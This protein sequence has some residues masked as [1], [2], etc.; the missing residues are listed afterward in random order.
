MTTGAC[1]FEDGSCVEVDTAADCAALGG[2]FQG[3]GT[4]CSGGCPSFAGA[5]C[6]ADGSCVLVDGPSDCEAQGGDFLGVGTDCSVGCPVLEGACCFE[7]GTCVITD[8][9]SEC[10]SLGGVFQGKGTDCSSGCPSFAGACCFGDGTCVIA[11]GPSDCAAQ[12]GNFLGVGTNCTECPSVVGAC[13]FSDGSCQQTDA[14]TCAA[15]GGQFHGVGSSCNFCNVQGLAAATWTISASPQDPFANVVSQPTFGVVERYLW[16]A[17][18]QFPFQPE[19]IAAAELGISS[20]GT[21]H[22]AT[23]PQNGFLN[24]GTTADL[25]LAVGGCPC[26]PVVAATLLVLDQPGAMCF[27]PSSVSGVKAAVDC[28]AN[29]EAWAMHWTGF[30][31]TGGQPCEK[32]FGCTL[33]SLEQMSW[34][35][36]KGM[37]R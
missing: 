6:F 10:A 17:C 9:A 13:C 3:K 21:I 11:D 15:L 8:S 34:G 29:P 2:L 12:G 23:T 27:A 22:L 31:N 20:T 16:L 24:A 32:G 25:L 28:R 18:C 7:D 19:G 37:Y 26:G 30:N 5:C 33:T 35:R 4:D 1:C 36:I 14:S